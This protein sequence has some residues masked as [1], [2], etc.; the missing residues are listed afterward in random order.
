MVRKI[1][2]QCSFSGSGMDCSDSADTWVD[3]LTGSGLGTDLVSGSRTNSVAGSVSVSLWAEK[4]SPTW[5]GQ[6][7]GWWRLYWFRGVVAD[8][9][10]LND[11]LCEGGSTYPQ[12]VID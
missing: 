7:D 10:F 6:R 3:L 9:V 4:M 2:S 5:N 11:C 12:G 8:S 1:M